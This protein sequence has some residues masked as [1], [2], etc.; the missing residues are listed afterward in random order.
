MSKSDKAK[1]QRI[2]VTVSPEMYELIHQ[3]SDEASIATS[4]LLGELV[5][6][7]KPAL[8][9]MLLAIRQAKNEQ[10]EAFDTLHKLLI[11]SQLEASNA[12]LDLLEQKGK[13]RRARSDKQRNGDR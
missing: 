10:S 1:Q 7:A 5:E 8:E 2:L 12:Q 4:A 13:L 9:A 3:L 6:R 11:D